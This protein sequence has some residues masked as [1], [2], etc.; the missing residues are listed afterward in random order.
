MKYIRYIICLFLISTLILTSCS[1]KNTE[2]T[3]YVDTL[4][5]TIISI[6][7]Y[8]NV[9][10]DIVSEC[11]KLCRKYENKFSRSNTSSEIYR[12]NHS[13]G[14]TV[15]LSDETIEL[16]ELG[17]H[18]SKLSNGVFDITIG[19]LSELWDFKNN[20]GIVPSSKDISEE[21]THVGYDKILIDGNQVR[22]LDAN[23]KVDLGGIAK[24]YIA[25]Q[26]KSYLLSQGVKHA[27]INLGGNVLAIENKPDGSD[28]LIGI[29]KPFDENGSAIT[30][31]NLN[32]QSLVSSGN[33]QRYFK[34]DDKIYHHIL[35]T[36]TG[37]PHDNELLGVTILCKSSTAADALSTICYSLGLEDGLRF[38]NQYDGAEA[39]F[40]TSDL[41]IHY[42]D[43]W[44]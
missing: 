36:S 28:Y 4:F 3:S 14:K 24:G 11:M 29:Q 38:I 26:L 9:S 17:I 35:D 25:D 32:N 23:T 37:Y 18:Y 41:E 44:Q 31:I 43:K 19:G 27:L 20:T 6:Q 33:Y 22:L 15:T 21:L 13:N 12:L 7:I 10:D 1:S 2:P 42:S 30:T 40:I 16:L 39:L 5:D 8:D 34:I